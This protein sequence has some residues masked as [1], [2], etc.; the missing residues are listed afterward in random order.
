MATRTKTKSKS[1][2]SH[3]KVGKKTKAPAF[4]SRRCVD[5][6]EKL[7]QL[8]PG[9]LCAWCA[10]ARVEADSNKRRA[11]PLQQAIVI[12]PNGETRV[13][14]LG[15]IGYYTGARTTR[16]LHHTVAAIRRVAIEPGYNA[17]VIDD[18]RS[19]PLNVHGLTVIQALGCFANLDSI[20]GDV[21]IT[22]PFGMTL[23]P[24]EI[25]KIM[26]L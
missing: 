14:P 11:V 15:D 5:C 17:R 26:K 9:S 13:I 8:G 24:G 22:G 10:S 12:T 25:D 16:T 1:S 4:P 23:L 19:L 20:F 3:K 18:S 7:S 6:K 2:L 21:I